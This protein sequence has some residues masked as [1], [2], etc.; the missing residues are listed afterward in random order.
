MIGNKNFNLDITLNFLN[1][2]KYTPITSVD[3]KHNFSLYKH[4][5]SNRQFSRTYFRNIYIYIYYK[6]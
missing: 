5:L 1:Y 3:V 2:F 6:F 4:I